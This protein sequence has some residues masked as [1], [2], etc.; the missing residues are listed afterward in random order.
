LR[1]V[2][3][4]YLNNEVM[5]QLAPPESEEPEGKVSVITRLESGV[6]PETSGP[7]ISTMVPLAVPSA[8]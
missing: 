5:K 4:N 3:A 1:K 6:L 2:C 8:S 7:D